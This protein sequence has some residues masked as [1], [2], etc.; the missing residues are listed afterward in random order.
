MNITEIVEHAQDSTTV[1]R[2]FGEPVTRGEVTVIPV[3]RVS[4]G[5]GGGSGKQEGERPGEGSG[6]GFGIGAVPTGVFVVR[7][8]KVR[9]RPAVD[10]NRV[11]LGAQLVAVIALFTVRAIARIRAKAGARR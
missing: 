6:G 5:G 8:G 3:A 10:V 2:A 11:I 4:G 9:W 1:K 7:N